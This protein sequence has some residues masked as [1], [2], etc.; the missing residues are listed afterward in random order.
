MRPR[1]LTFHRKLYVFLVERAIGVGGGWERCGRVLLPDNAF[2][3]EIAHVL[4]VFGMRVPRVSPPFGDRISWTYAFS[5]GHSPGNVRGLS[6]PIAWPVARITDMNDI[7]LMR[8]VSERASD[9]R[10][11]SGDVGRKKL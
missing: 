1:Q 10:R 4:R 9:C 11:D 6:A 3:E 7:P 2:R 5:P 8:L